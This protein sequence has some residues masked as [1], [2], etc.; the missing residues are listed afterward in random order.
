MYLG[1]GV[2]AIE[3]RQNTKTVHA[4]MVAYVPLTV[5]LV[6]VYAKG[7]QP[8]EKN[9][10][11]ASP[12]LTGK[13]QKN[14]EACLDNLS[15]FWAVCRSAA[16]KQEHNMELDEAVFQDTGLL[17]KTGYY[18]KIPKGTK[19]NV[20]ISVLRNVKKIA[21]N[22]VLTFPFAASLEE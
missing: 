21:K 15:P 2:G 19:F 11:V 7:S 12:L 9:F 10:L 20:E 5:R 18:P 8:K 4:A 6:N 13:L 3:A 16:L 17:I 1:D 22:E 14:R